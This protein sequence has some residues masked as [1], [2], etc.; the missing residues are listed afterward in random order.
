MSAHKVQ[1]IKDGP[2]EISGPFVYVDED[3]TEF[4]VKTETSLLCRCG[5]SKK[6]PFC[7]GSHSTALF[8]ATTKFS[9][10][11]TITGRS[12]DDNGDKLVVRLMRGGPLYVSGD[13]IV[14]GSCGASWSG[15]RAKLCRCGLS[16]SK[17]FCD[18]SHK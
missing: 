9:T 18:G 7:D 8:E 15:N 1:V 16:S 11:Y 5:H 13:L 6:P 2:L 3:A 10:D 4:E 17:P 12:I 14:L